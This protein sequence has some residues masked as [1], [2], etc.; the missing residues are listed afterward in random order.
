MCVFVCAREIDRE[1]L[2]RQSISDLISKQGIKHER[3]LSLTAFHFFEQ[4]VTQCPEI[5]MDQVLVSF[6]VAV[7]ATLSGGGLQPK[8][9][10]NELSCKCFLSSVVFGS[11]V[12]LLLFYNIYLNYIF[13]QTNRQLALMLRYMGLSLGTCAPCTI[14]K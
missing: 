7:N 11:Y 6:S 14:F 13:R 5:K 8:L 4:F 9:K 2:R 10:I 1:E 3:F 12:R